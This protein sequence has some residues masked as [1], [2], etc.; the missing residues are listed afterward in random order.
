MDRDELVEE[1]L[2][3]ARDFINKNR[4]SDAGIR[5]ML[6]YILTKIELSKLHQ[7]TVSGSNTVNKCKQ[8]GKE[9]EERFNFCSGMCK[10]YYYR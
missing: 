6:R 3:V 10:A 2:P 9:I 1:L 4:L 7:P 8:C 5:T